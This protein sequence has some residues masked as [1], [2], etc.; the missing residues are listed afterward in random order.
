MSTVTNDA[1]SGADCRHCSISL[2]LFSVAAAQEYSACS[3]FSAAAAFSSMF[4]RFTRSICV[5]SSSSS[6]EWNLLS[7]SHHVRCAHQIAAAMPSAKATKIGGLRFSR[8]AAR[9]T[10]SALELEAGAGAR[11]ACRR[12]VRSMISALTGSG[13]RRRRRAVDRRPVAG[14]ADRCDARSAVAARGEL[15]LRL[16]GRGD[17]QA[18]NAGEV[19]GIGGALWA[20]SGAGH[21]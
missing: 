13:T 19:A 10:S 15:E 17:R 18:A 8:S 6:R 2:I 5:E 16:G 4:A 9:S 1:L 7:L 3:A 11:G 12:P 21:L 14:G 20:C